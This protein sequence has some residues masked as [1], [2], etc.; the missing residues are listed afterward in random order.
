MVQV[1]QEFTGAVQKN[2]EFLTKKNVKKASKQTRK[3]VHEENKKGIIMQ[4]LLL[5][6]GSSTYV[7]SKSQG[8]SLCD[9]PINNNRSIVVQTVTKN[10]KGRYVWST[11]SIDGADYEVMFPE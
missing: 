1:N 8:Q 9:D 3:L 6:S 4:L 11:E 10:D 7:H 2:N 5:S